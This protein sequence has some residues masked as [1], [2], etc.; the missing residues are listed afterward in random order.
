M[1]LV[2]E[3]DLPL[4][5]KWRNHETIRPFMDDCRMVTPQV[6][7]VWLNK[8]R[9]SN[10][11]LAYMCSTAKTAVGFTELKKIDWERRSCEGGIFLFGEKYFGT[12]LAY[13]IA[14]CREIIMQRLGLTVLVS[15]IRKKNLRGIQFCKKYGGKYQGEEKDFLIFVHA[16]APRMEGL[17]RLAEKIERAAEFAHIFKT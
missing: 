1:R 10:T 17:Q 5:C 14:L 11:S 2:K 9:A 12:G 3:Q 13:S 6:M 16:Y 4:L 7:T 8:Q 15:R